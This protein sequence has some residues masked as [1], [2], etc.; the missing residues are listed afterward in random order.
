MSYLDFYFFIFLFLSF[1]VYFVIPS[2]FRKIVILISSLVFYVCAGWEKIIFLI[3][4]FLITYFASWKINSL[5]SGKSGTGDSKKIA[6]RY[7]KISVFAIILI[8]VLF[9]AA[10]FLTSSSGILSSWRSVY[11]FLVPLGLSYYTFSSVG[12]ILDV[13]W[14]KANFE[15]NAL[16]LFACII[17]FPHI[18]EGPINRYGKM[19]A[20]FE[21]LPGFQFK[22]V[23][24]GFQRMIW[25][26]FKKLVIADRISVVTSSIF[27][28]L[29][30]YDGGFV[31]FGMLLNVVHIYADFSG[32]MDIVLGISE[33][34]GIK[35]EENF[36]HPFFS[37]SIAEFWRRWHMT[38]CSWFKNYIYMPL[39]VSQIHIKMIMKLRKKHGTT[40]SRMYATIVPMLVVWILTGLWHGTG[41]NYVLWGVYYAVLMSAGVLLQKK[42]KKMK[43]F[44]KIDDCSKGWKLFSIIR[45]FFLFAIGRMITVLNRW[46]SLAVV[47]KRLLRRWNP[48]IFFDGSLY[49]LGLDRQNFTLMI[50]TVIFLFAV[51]FLQTK[52]SVRELIARKNIVLRWIVY[53]AA[54]CSVIIFGMYGPG[55]NASSFVYGNF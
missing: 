49:K 41:W 37:S 34:Y 25:G 39:S 8:L 7:V 3:V 38:L 6:S 50:L 2:R 52:G 12:Y 36:N 24:F 43:E 11:S 14:K 22:R 16:T 31:L 54:I 1:A 32:C 13:Y 26:Y 29:D 48:W 35:M 47:M 23:C 55:Y 5:Y 9:K 28:N 42:F 15:K 18:V 46:D 10:N 45:T 51:E 20:Q 27:G 40:F 33:A 19:F 53:F 44:F 4:D 17:Y 21:R 30:L